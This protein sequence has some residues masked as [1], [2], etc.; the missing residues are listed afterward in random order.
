M[1][2]HVELWDI[3]HYVLAVD[4]HDFT[5]WTSL[6]YVLADSAQAMFAVDAALASAGHDELLAIWTALFGPS[7][8]ERDVAYSLRDSL[9]EAA[10]RPAARLRV[11]SRELKRGFAGEP[12][13]RKQ[14]EQTPR[15]ETEHYIVVQAVSVEEMPVPGV[16]LELVIAGGEV[17]GALT[18]KDGLAR[19]ERIHAGNVVIRVLSVDGDL[20]EALDGAA[21]KPSS[22][23]DRVRW[24]TVAQGECL[25]K[26]AHQYNL[27]GWKKLWEHPRNEPLRK[28][29]KSPHVLLPGDAVALPGIDVYEIVRPTDATHRIKVKN[30]TSTARAVVVFR[31]SEGEALSSEAYE[32]RYEDGGTSHSK[33]GQL[34][35]SG[36]LRE[37]L[38]VTVQHVEVLLPDLGQRYQLKLGHLDPTEDGQ[39]KF[40]ASGVEGR[41]AALGYLH[42]E[43][44]ATHIE[45]SKAAVS[46]FQQRVMGRK[47]ASGELDA[48]TCRKLEETYGV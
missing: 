42:R 8:P 38:P 40:V 14:P 11:L 43:A 35:G 6:G 15:L 10:L 31:D 9:R 30:S 7:S 23:D 44:A 47:E 20:W 48:E 18:D 1:S 3:D 32:L 25:S 17:K 29:R 27:D 4:Q 36:E 22:T 13:Q 12:F 24:H 21:S 45:D 33:Q 41:L 26:I 28:K 2:S 19:V 16:Q 37:E 5:R 46:A 39:G 34:S